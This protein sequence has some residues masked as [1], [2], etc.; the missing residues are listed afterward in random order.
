MTQ[1]MSAAA[2]LLLFVAVGPSAGELFS[3]AL[4][5]E[6]AGDDRQA[7]ALLER[8]TRQ[9]P[10]WEAPRV[11]AARLLLKGAIDLS[12]AELH[13]EVAQS[14]APEN[15]RVHYYWG[16]LMEE[17]RRPQEALAALERAVYFRRG[18]T[19]AEFRLAGLYLASGR[20][21]RACA[22]YRRVTQREPANLGAGLQLARCL[23]RLSRTV[24]AEAELLRLYHRSPKL[25][26]TAQSLADFYVRTGREELAAPI[27]RRLNPNKVNPPKRELRPSRR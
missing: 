18:Y 24:E 11:E 15:A 7:L 10:A 27:R 25:P 20:D 22:L 1:G 23:E 26:S 14:V 8:A 17:R 12:R 13:L 9:S 5:A 16:V 21:E 3:Q 19:E 6:A 2:L 4:A